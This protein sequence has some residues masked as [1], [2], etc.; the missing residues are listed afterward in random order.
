MHLSNRSMLKLDPWKLGYT[1]CILTIPR[2]HYGTGHL[3][4]L[5]DGPFC[6]DDEANIDDNVVVVVVVVVVGDDV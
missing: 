3:L 6:T 1:Q 2:V 5:S 4:K